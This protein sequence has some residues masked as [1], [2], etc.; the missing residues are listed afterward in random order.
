MLAEVC[1]FLKGSATA[2][3]TVQE[4]HEVVL[5]CNAQAPSSVVV[6][7]NSERMLLK[8]FCEVCQW[9]HWR[10]GLITILN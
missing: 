6:R 3:T 1:V 9:C 10:N 7:D 5:G 2:L 4:G 8:E